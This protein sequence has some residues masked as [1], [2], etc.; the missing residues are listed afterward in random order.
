MQIIQATSFSASQCYLGEGPMWHSRRKSYFWVDIDR[1]RFYECA[2][3]GTT[4]QLYKTPEKTSLLVELDYDNLLIGMKGGLAKFNLKTNEVNWLVEIERDIPNNRSNDGGCDSEGRLWIGMM[5]MQF[6]PGAGALYCIDKNSRV[7]KKIPGTAISNGLVWSP[8]NK[9]MYYI[10]TPTQKV[11][12]FLYDSITGNLTYEKD[13][14]HVSKENGS[15]DGM[16]MD[17]EGMLWIAQWGGFGV[18]RWNPLTGEQI[19][20]IQLP[21]PN[22]SSCTFAGENLDQLIITTARQDLSPEELKKFPESGD[23]FIADPGVRGRP[24]FKCKLNVFPK[25]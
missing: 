23:V 16:A 6:K 8:D 7:E 20:L 18:Y 19:G 15:P 11:Q 22:V 24:L 21:V 9:R 14:I 3:Q 1:Y 4:P 25:K 13:I 12:S 2:A 5:D 17:E 10:D